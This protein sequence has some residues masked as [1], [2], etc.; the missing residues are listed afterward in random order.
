MNMDSPKNEAQMK[1]R[2]EVEA[3]KNDRDRQFHQQIEIFIQQQYGVFVPAL[4]FEYRPTQTSQQRQKEFSGWDYE[5]L[6][7]FFSHFGDV[8]L[9]EIYG[10][11]SVILFKTFIDAHSTKEFLD[12][13]NNFK[14]SEK[15]NFIVRWYSIEDEVLISELLRSKLKRPTPNQLV[16]NL[17]YWGNQSLKEKEY[18]PTYNS[19]NYYNTRGENLF[20]NSSEYFTTNFNGQYNYYAAMSLNP[21]AREEFNLVVNSGSPSS[22]TYDEEGKQNQDKFL[23]N[24]KYTCKFEIQIENDNEFQVARRLIGAKG[25]NMKKI[26]ELCARDREGK[27]IPDAVKL[28]LRGR[29]SGYK[30]GPYNRGK[31]FILSKF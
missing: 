25:C 18:Y 8:E 23:T 3:P 24:G 22:N 5:D 11:K 7:E 4:V 10:K 2:T 16:D 1:E 26:V 13:S 9:L 31:F 30:E 20:S 12:N 29:G 6:L 14:D 17:N 15:D 19:Q 21:K 27:F 28:R